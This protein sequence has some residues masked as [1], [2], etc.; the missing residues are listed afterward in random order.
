MASCE[1]KKNANTESVASDS[2]DVPTAINNDSCPGGVYIKYA[3]VY[4]NFIVEN[5]GYILETNIEF[6]KAVRR[7]EP[8]EIVEGFYKSLKEQTK[9]SI[10]T[11]SKLCAFNGD[12]DYKNTAIAL[13]KFYDEI[14]EDYRSLLT[15]KNKDERAKV[16]E[17]IKVK[18]NEAHSK[19]EKMLEKDFEKASTKFINEYKLHIRRTHLHE[20]QDSLLFL[21]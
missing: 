3:H 9:Y 4:N 14:W 12:L 13:F 21:K 2:A 1:S 5:Q 20:R 8:N 6:V 16:L 19:R 18:F 11:V 17:V 15:I 10:D 7:Q